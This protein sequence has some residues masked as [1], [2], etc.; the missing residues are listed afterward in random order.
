MVDSGVELGWFGRA[1]ILGSRMMLPLRSIAE[2]E[3]H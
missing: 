2:M 1:L 3:P